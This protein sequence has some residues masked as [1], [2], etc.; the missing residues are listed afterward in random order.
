MRALPEKDLERALKKKGRKLLRTH[1]EETGALDAAA[2]RGAADAH[3][4]DAVCDL[5][6]KPRGR[7]EFKEGKPERG[8]FDAQQ[9][10]NFALRK[11][12]NGDKSSVTLRVNA[13]HGM[14]ASIAS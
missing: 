14:T 11:K 13:S 6:L 1:L 9:M 8:R 10:A 7:F 3:L 2:Y 4:R 5:F 12:L